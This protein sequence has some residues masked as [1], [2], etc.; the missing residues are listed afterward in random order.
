[1][2]IMATDFMAT[3]HD[4]H[5]NDKEYLILHPVADITRYHGFE[6]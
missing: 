1:M 2:T 3:L 5:S 6:I 4:G